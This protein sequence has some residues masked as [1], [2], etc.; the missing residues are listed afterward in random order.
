MLRE[1]RDVRL[2][3]GMVRGNKPARQTRIPISISHNPFTVQRASLCV[4]PWCTRS[5]SAAPAPRAS[6]CDDVSR[7]ARPSGVPTA[8]YGLRGRDKG[9]SKTLRTPSRAVAC[10][11]ANR[12]VLPSSVFWAASSS[13][14]RLDRAGFQ[15]SSSNSGGASGMSCGCAGPR[16]SGE[17]TASL[18]EGAVAPP[19]ISALISTSSP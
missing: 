2:E 16:P 6:G 7:D 15:S 18:T 8:Q 13:S 12:L 5:A 11:C 17:A 14:C 9:T 19:L 10:A 4:D 3:I 1:Q